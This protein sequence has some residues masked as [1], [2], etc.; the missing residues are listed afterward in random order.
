MTV[1]KITVQAQR[2]GNEQNKRLSIIRRQNKKSK[3]NGIEKTTR[4][5]QSRWNG[6]NE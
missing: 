3:Q 1:P 6:N 2:D 5:L 4:K